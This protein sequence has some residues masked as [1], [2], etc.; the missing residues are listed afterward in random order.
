LLWVLGAP[1][2]HLSRFEHLA[3]EKYSPEAQGLKP[4]RL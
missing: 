1:F 3:G 2:G 4:Y